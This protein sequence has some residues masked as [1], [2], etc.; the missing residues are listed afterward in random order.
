[1]VSQIAEAEK[2]NKEVLLH[3]TDEMNALKK[4]VEDGKLTFKTLKLSL[5]LFLSIYLSF[6][7]S[8]FIY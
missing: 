2:Q 4:Q 5:S 7:Q 3:L 8:L 6:S 1:M